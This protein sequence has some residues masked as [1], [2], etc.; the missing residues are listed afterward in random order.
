MIIQI[1]IPPKRASIACLWVINPLEV[2]K[3]MCEVKVVLVKTS[4]D[5]YEKVIAS[6]DLL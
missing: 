6:E 1:N 4:N 5:L 2:L 3:I